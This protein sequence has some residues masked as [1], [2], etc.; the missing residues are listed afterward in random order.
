MAAEIRKFALTVGND[1]NPQVFTLSEAMGES[2][3]AVGRKVVS[4]LP[5]FEWS[6]VS[7]AVVA[8]LKKSG[9]P[10]S[11]LEFSHSEP[12][13]ISEPEGVR[14]A[15]IMAVTKQVKDPMRAYNLYT[16]VGTMGLEETYY[17]YAKV[18]GGNY[19]RGVKALRVLLVG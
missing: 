17:W 13:I 16:A 8:A 9:H 2:A 1:T 18:F 10:A 19:S 5:Q 7:K 14:L 4:T 15:L 11:A 3:P 6:V 12:L